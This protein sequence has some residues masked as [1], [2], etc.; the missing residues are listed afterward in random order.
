MESALPT[1]VLGRGQVK[2]AMAAGSQPASEVG[3]ERMAG[4]VVDHNIHGHVR[5]AAQRWVRVEFWAA[6]WS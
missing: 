5:D 2:D 4:E 6:I 1:E 3:L